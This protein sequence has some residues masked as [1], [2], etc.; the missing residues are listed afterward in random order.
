MIKKLYKTLLP[1]KKRINLRVFTEKLFYPLYLGSKFHCNCCGKN[2]RKFKNKGNI[3]RLNAKCPYCLSLERTRVLDLYLEKELNIYNKEG[4]KVLHF[5]PE[6]CLSKKLSSIKNVEYI[7]GDINPAYAN[8]IIDITD[9]KYDNL[10]FD[11][12]ICSHV[13]GHVPNEALAIQE[14]KRVLKKDGVAIVMTL[15]N[16][17]SDHTFEDK[18]IVKEEDRLKFYTE[19]D[20]CRLHGL[21]F[22]D[23]L[24]QQGFKV[25]EIDYRKSFSEKEQNRLSL[26][27]G[28]REIIFRCEKSA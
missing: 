26:G 11:L 12:I 27:N 7:D 16:L 1:E 23:R 8:N 18:N 4:I 10:Y 13:L 9:I 21:D 19:K 14:M 25:Q 6:D 20:L 24:S 2:F 17:E 28:S 15:I 3:N 22:A 5:A